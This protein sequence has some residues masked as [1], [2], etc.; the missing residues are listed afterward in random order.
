MFR[1]GIAQFVGSW[2]S[3]SGY[4][5]RIKKVRKDR[6]SVDFLDPRG[7]PVKRT[8]M[9]GAP[10]IKMIAQ[11]DDYYENFEVDLW[12]R[13]K[14]FILHLDHEYGYL[15]DREQREVLVPAISRYERDHF[16]ELF[17]HYLA[18]WITLC[19]ERRKTKGKRPFF[20]ADPPS[21]GIS[22]HGRQ[23]RG[24]FPPTTQPTARSVLYDLERLARPLAVPAVL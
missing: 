10:S 2:V 18:P 11:Y 5:L 13:G 19:E 23:I 21:D 15:L 22:V 8:Y 16:L 9:E 3:E 7:V 4:C 20:L 1:N 6:A 12:E 14:G 17:T 24:R